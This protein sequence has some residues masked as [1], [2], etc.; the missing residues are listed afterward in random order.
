MCGRFTRR[1]SWREVHDFLDL[2]LPDPPREGLPP[3]YNVAPTQPSPVCRLSPS[4]AGRELD[5]LQ[6]GLV[7]SWSTDASRGII[8]ARC[9]TAADKPSFRSA[10]A[11]RRCLVPVS[12]FYEW[13]KVEGSTRK[14]PW[15]F[16]CSNGAPLAFAGLWECWRGD[17]SSP[18]LETFCILTTR[19]NELMRPIHDR[20]PV[21]IRPE[22]FGRW[23][24]PGAAADDLL[25]PIESSE[26][27]AWPVGT[28]VNNPTVDDP[29]LIEAVEVAGHAQR[30]REGGDEQATMF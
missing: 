9:E 14:Q 6:W 15:Y 18:P 13:Q 11:K 19:A 23:L 20:M 29:S 22:S 27:A 7:P 10:Y 25:G 1:Y 16:E 28:R 8:N 21:I 17:G 12:G 2:Q 26:L 5:V 3:S 24:E 30:E 4:G